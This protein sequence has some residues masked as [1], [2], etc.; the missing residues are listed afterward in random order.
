[1]F[2]AGGSRRANAPPIILDRGGGRHDISDGTARENCWRTLGPAIVRGNASE[3]RA[4]A[5]DERSVR[6]VDS[7][8]ESA[9]VGPNR[10]I[11][12]SARYGAW[13]GEPAAPVDLISSGEDDSVFNGHP[14]DARCQGDGPGCT[15]ARDRRIPRP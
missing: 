15:P 13:G 1:M 9:Y 6:G 10:R 11:E 7:A 14:I 8:Y 12:L 3:I 2:K 5:D 4:L